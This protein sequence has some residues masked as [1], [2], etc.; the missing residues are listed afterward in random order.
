MPLSTVLFRIGRL[1]R[2]GHVDRIANPDDGRSYLV[3]LSDEGK[4]LLGKARPAFR[5]YA[6][7]VDE[8]LGPERVEALR[9]AAGGAAP[10]SRGRAGGARAASVGRRLPVRGGCG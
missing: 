6:E 4:R 8:R 9:S 7:A 10:G 1:E 2:R 3:S 5:D